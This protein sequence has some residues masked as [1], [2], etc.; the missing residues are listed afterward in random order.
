MRKEWFV[1][2]GWFYRPVSAIGWTLT[3]GAAALCVWVGILADRHSHST[4][5]TLIDTFPYAALFVIIL[6]WIA[7]HS[8]GARPKA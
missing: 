4:S 6:G 8:S 5:D 1:C 3:F 7:S 2:F